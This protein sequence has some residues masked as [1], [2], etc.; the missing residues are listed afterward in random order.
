MTVY[1]KM[2][3]ANHRLP[4]LILSVPSCKILIHCIV[5]IRYI[6]STIQECRH[7]FLGILAP[8]NSTV[9]EYLEQPRCSI[10]TSTLTASPLSN[11]NF[12]LPHFYPSWNGEDTSPPPRRIPGFLSNVAVEE[13]HLLTSS[14]PSTL[15][16]L[17]SRL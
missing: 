16:C 15:H 13:P 17:A 3:R 2:I 6:T 4:F 8:S 12:H 7:S 10:S 5:W 14:L 1:N 11:P 9:L